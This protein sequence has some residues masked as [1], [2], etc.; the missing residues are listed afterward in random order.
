MSSSLNRI[1]KNIIEAMQSANKQGTSAYDSVAEVRRV[2]GD[3]A[4]VHIAG[5]VDETPV[6]L[7]IA[8]KAGDMVQ[9]RVGGGRAWITGN[10]SA[11]PTDDHM[12]NIANTTAKIAGVTANKALREA[13]TAQEKTDDLAVEMAGAV[14]SINRDITDLQDQIDGNITTWFY[15]VDPTMDLP[16]AVDW[17][18]DEK[19]NTHLGDIYY[20]TVKGYA[21]RFMK[22]GDVYSWERITD[23]DVTKALADAATAQDT[24]DSKRRVFYNTPTV[25]Y[26][27]GD[28]WVQGSG[29]DILRCA[30][31]KTSTGS[32]D[33]NDWVLASKYTDDSTLNTWLTNTYAVDK[34]NLQEQ[35]DGK[36]E[37]WYQATDPSSDWSDAD[38][39][40]H[41]GD[42]WYNTSDNT[43]WY[44]TGSAWSQ[45]SIPTSVFNNI[46]GKANIFVGSTAPESPKTGDLWLES[47]SSDILTYV[48]GS[49]VKYNKY[50]DDTKAKQAQAE[51]DNIKKRVVIGDDSVDIV[52]STGKLLASYGDAKVELGKNAVS[53]IIEMCGGMARVSARYGGLTAIYSNNGGY[54]TTLDYDFNETTFKS[55]VGS[56]YGSYEFV[57]SGGIWEYSYSGN[58]AGYVQ[59]NL[60]DYG[61]TLKTTSVNEYAGI[62]IQYWDGSEATFI[63]TDTTKPSRKLILGLA[64]SGTSDNT[65]YANI[66]IER[67][68]EDGVE[69]SKINLL[70]VHDE[71][72]FAGVHLD[73]GDIELN[74]SGEVLINQYNV[75]QRLKDMLC[76]EYTEQLTVKAGTFTNNGCSATLVG[77]SLYLYLKATAKAAIS[78]GNIANQTMLTITFT[79]SKIA[80]L[81]SVSGS[82]G[83]SGPNSQMLFTGASSG[84]QHTITVTLAAIAQNI[85]KG[86]EINAKV[87][88]PCVL[89]WDAY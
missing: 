74:C 78:A 66:E 17:D 22:S 30:Q 4:W 63:N 3:T 55:K 42:L 83:S 59:V 26:D 85:A 47:A 81:Y 24:A 28:L 76:T 82:G 60:S 5:G 87:S 89:D 72:N 49:W 8:A 77:N 71:A 70:T 13:E 53:S 75:V 62:S 84:G 65:D 69:H 67:S 16:P 58:D 12:A 36:A 86:G 44:Y 23:T 7:T 54:Q 57:Y 52:D 88:I 9:V 51:I 48:D 61:I 45:Q 79:D 6:K 35:I 31:A 15:D 40:N 18:T 11:P 1:R 25:P 19:K 34:T 10:A 27:A 56:N 37:T 80:T 73:N 38:K 20:N 14:L 39:P 64:E 21:W 41:E 2:E 50:T 46:N 33:R 43:T 32:Y 68:K 29:G